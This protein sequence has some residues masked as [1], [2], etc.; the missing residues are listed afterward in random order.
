MRAASRS[1]G[2]QRDVIVDHAMAREVEQDDSVLHDQPDEQDQ[3]HERRHVERRARDQQQHHR[4]DE[5]QRRGEQHD[6]RLDERLE[7]DHHHGDHAQRREREHEQQ[8]VERLLLARVLAAEL[9]ANPARRRVCA[10][11]LFT[12]VITRAERATAHVGGDRDHLL[13]VLARRAPRASPSA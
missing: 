2:L 13:L 3:P 4:A 9:D 11:T 8:R 7:L 12:S 6:Q 10:S 5:R 1:R